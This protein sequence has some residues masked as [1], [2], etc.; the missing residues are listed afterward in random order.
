MDPALLKS[1]HGMED[2]DVEG[3]VPKILCNEKARTEMR[4]RLEVYYTNIQRSRSVTQFGKIFGSISAAQCLE[5]HHV[6]L[7][8]G[9]NIDVQKNEL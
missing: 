5:N 8:L 6:L 2:A 1:L 9:R 4:Q 7:K 3:I